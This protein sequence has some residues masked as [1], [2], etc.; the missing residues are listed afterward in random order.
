L[1]IFFGK[2]QVTNLEES[3]AKL[4]AVDGFSMY[5]IAKSEFIRRSMQDSGLKLPKNSSDISALIHKFF[6]RVRSE[7]IEKHNL[8]K[9]ENKKI[10]ISIDEWTSLRNRR[11]MNVHVYN[12]VNSYD[13]GLVRIHGTCPAEKVFSL[14][15]DVGIISFEI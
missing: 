11:Y 10:S 3:L 5:S 6:E 12:D 2:R 14:V 9:K 7:Y 4:A 8:L 13:L 15:N 1:N